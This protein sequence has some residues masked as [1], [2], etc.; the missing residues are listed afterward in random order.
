MRA[1][2]CAEVHRYKLGLAYLYAPTYK[3]EANGIHV[4]IF[5]KSARPSHAAIDHALPSYRLGHALT[6]HT[7]LYPHL[8]RS[9]F[10]RN[11]QQRNSAHLQH[12]HQLDQATCAVKAISSE[13]R[14]LPKRSLK[15][16]ANLVVLIIQTLIAQADNKQHSLKTARHG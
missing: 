15:I 12:R 9:T 8:G 14:S 2:I 6:V 4:V 16:S 1:S 11:Y 7:V 3:K 5:H 10:S 13:D